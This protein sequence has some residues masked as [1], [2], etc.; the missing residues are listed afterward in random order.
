MKNIVKYLVISLFAISSFSA[1]Q[2]GELSVTGSAKASYTITSSDGSAG[3]Q[4]KGK[5][6]GVVNEF[7]F[8]ASGENDF[9]TWAYATDFDGGTLLDDAQLTLTTDMGTF[10]VFI[11]EGGLDTDSAGS[12]SVVS[13]PS[14]TSFDEGMFDSFDLSGS[15]TVQY[16]TP[17]D[18]LP[19]GIGFKV[20]YAP[21]N[22]ST[23]QGTATTALN[24]Y[25]AGGSANTGAFTANSQTEILQTAQMGTSATHYQVTAA[26]ITG[27]T[28]GGDYV[29]FSGVVG[30][31]S[32]SPE[33]GS[34]YAVYAMGPAKIGY[35]RN[36][37][38]F[39]IGAQTAGSGTD[40]IESVKGSKYSI[41]MNLNE[42]FSISYEHE[43]S[44]PNNQT[45]ATV[46]PSITSKGVQ[47]AYTVGGM[48][49]AVAMNDHKNASY[50]ENKNVTDTVLS[51]AM[52]F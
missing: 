43:K 40:Y 36:Y 34:V 13:R 52:A 21:S 49:L 47:A 33:S 20:A 22:S 11:S 39:A 12:Q 50:T 8:G 1:A 38:S 9:G 4:E 27:L 16:H 37:A 15:N 5:S 6:L 3:A 35:S 17:A 26:P 44:T 46:K 2:A 31:K 32:Q 10:G 41:G 48:T 30:A 25:K 51:I 7:T 14:D 29:E 19:F 28:I 18:L 45:A 24:D 42:S 23:T